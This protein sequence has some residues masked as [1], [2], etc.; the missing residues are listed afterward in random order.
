MTILPTKAI[1]RNVF[2]PCIWRSGHHDT[3]QMIEGRFGGILTFL[4]LA[5]PRE[6]NCGI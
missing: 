4:G 1:R 6:K 5:I 2:S 3:H